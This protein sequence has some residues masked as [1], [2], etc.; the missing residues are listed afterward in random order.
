MV[1]AGN[2]GPEYLKRLG[3]ASRFKLS[4]FDLR[5]AIE[6]AELIRKVK[7]EQN[8]QDLGTWAKVKFDIQIVAIAVAEGCQAIYSEDDHIESHARR[9]NIDVR[10]ICDLEEP[11]TEQAGLF[12]T[13]GE[14]D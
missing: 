4:A 6:A 11:V 5:G 3:D 13:T 12:E 14:I 9:V 8:A 2:A 10:R 7:D 1:R